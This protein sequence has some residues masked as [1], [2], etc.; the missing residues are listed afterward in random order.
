VDTEQIKGEAR[1][2]PKAGERMV[3]VSGELKWQEMPRRIT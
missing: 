3:L 2:R 1:L